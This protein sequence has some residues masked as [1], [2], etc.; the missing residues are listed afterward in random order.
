MANVF[1]RLIRS[2]KKDAPVVPQKE[3][4]KL[5]EF[6]FYLHSLLDYDK[7]L[8]KSDY[9]HLVDEYADIF[10]TFNKLQETRMLEHYCSTNNC[11]IKRINDFISC[12]RE[13]KEDEDSS[14]IRKHNEKFLS[15]HL[16]SEKSYLDGILSEVDPNIKLDNE[17]RKVVLLDED[18]TLVIAGAGAGK[19]TTVSAKVKYLVERKG[20]RPDQI[21]V[22]SF[23]NKAVGELQDKINKALKIDCP[24]TTFHKTGYAIRRRQ[25]TEERV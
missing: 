19:T 23:T 25:E 15:D 22:I 18:Y 14:V 2:F 11:R 7:Y 13:L 10:A 8:A 12:Y 5:D 16:A 4:L 9:L 1:S 24:V 20:I 17:Q 3:L 6:E 21:L